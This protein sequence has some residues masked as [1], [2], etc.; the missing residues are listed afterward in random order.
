MTAT[1]SGAGYELIGHEVKVS[2]A[3]LLAELA[4]PTK[5]DPWMRYCNRW[6]LVIPTMALADGLDLPETWGVMTP[7]SGR[8]TRSMT[9]ERKAPALKPHE[10]SPALRT[11]A[12]WLHWRHHNAELHLKSAQ[13]E[14]DEL[15]RANDDLQI[16]ARGTDGRQSP[17]Q[18]AVA[19]IVRG[20]GIGYGGQIG[21][22]WNL[23]IKADDVIAELRELGAIRARAE[24]LADHIK[25][26][27][28]SLR[29]IRDGCEQLL[30]QATE[31]PVGGGGG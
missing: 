4:D 6:Y 3:D 26:D 28:S 20:V 5:S 16:R 13:R 11:I 12:T 19:E 10:Q 22:D 7:P 30:K 15:R 24:R 8:R 18:R 17:L 29:T 25:Y 21:D 9:V 1:T 31:K 2:R 23:S 27:L 14:R